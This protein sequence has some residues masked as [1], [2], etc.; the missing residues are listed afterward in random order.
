MESQRPK[1][2]RCGGEVSEA[3][4]A[5][6]RSQRALRHADTPSVLDAINQ[7]EGSC[8]VSSADMAAALEAKL[9]SRRDAQ[10]EN[11]VRRHGVPSRWVVELAV[12]N[13]D[14]LFTPPTEGPICRP[15]AREALPQALISASMDAAPSSEFEEQQVA[16]IE[17]RR[18]LRQG[19]RSLQI[20]PAALSRSEP[21]GQP[22]AAPI[23]TAVESAHHE[24]SLGRRV[25]PVATGVIVGRDAGE[26]V[27]LRRMNSFERSTSVPVLFTTK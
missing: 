2:G 17:H 6:R 24:L 13:D 5:F 18:R 3:R 8:S 9:K 23:A 20:S 4:G 7:T 26:A 22:A 14:A 11:A 10:I 19:E 25:R 21:P 15:P 12:E 1:R 27:L 16:N